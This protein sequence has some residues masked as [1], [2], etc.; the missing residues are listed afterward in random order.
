MNV[1]AI[2]L[3]L[4]TVANDVN[5]DSEFQPQISQIPKILESELK[6]LGARNARESG[7]TTR[8]QRHDQSPESGFLMPW[9]LG[10]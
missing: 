7:F 8:A 3:A 2:V 1:A 4:R 5:S 10:S 6:L 9:S